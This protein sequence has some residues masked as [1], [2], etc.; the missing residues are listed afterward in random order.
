MFCCTPLTDPNVQGQP[1]YFFLIF[2][3][4][5]YLFIFSFCFVLFFLLFLVFFVCVFFFC[6]FVF[7]FVFLFLIKKFKFFPQNCFSS[8]FQSIK[9]TP[10]QTA[11]TTDKNVLFFI[12][13]PDKH[14]CCV[15]NH[16]TILCLTSLYLLS[17]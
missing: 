7:A 3:L 2:Y 5:I 13:I 14:F 16:L 12:N 11:R 4:F 6:F 1:K 8:K 9:L 17:F 15:T 10:R